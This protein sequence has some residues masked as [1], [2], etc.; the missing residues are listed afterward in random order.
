MS[1]LMNTEDAQCL[2]GALSEC[3]LE[4]QEFGG[5]NPIPA[6]VILNVS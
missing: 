5:K 1:L 2:F 4:D 6:N 3:S